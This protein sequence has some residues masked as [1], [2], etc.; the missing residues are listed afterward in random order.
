MIRYAG[1]VTLLFLPLIAITLLIRRRFQRLT[2]SLAN[3]EYGPV[4]SVRI[5]ARNEADVI[6]PTIAI[7]LDQ[8]QPLLE[9][10]VLDGGSWDG[11]AEIARRIGEGNERLRVRPGRPQPTGWTGKNWA[12]AQL[13]DAARGSRLLFTDAEVRWESGA[14]PLLPCARPLLCRRHDPSRGQSAHGGV[15]GEGGGG[16]GDGG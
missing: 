4:T 7:L 15:V 9:L 3:V 5:P 12:C 1:A 8:R 2:P 6:G 10:L 11:M 13:T 14:Q 16:D